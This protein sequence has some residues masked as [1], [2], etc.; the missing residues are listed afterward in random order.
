MC[1]LPNSPRADFRHTYMLWQNTLW[2]KKKGFLPLTASDQ[3]S[4]L[5]TLSLQDPPFPTKCDHDD[6]EHE[7][8]TPDM[9]WPVNPTQLHISDSFCLRHWPLNL[10]AKP[11]SRTCHI[12]HWGD[13]ARKIEAHDNRPSPQPSPLCWV[14]T[15]SS[16]DP[17]CGSPAP[18]QDSSE[19][20]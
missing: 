5:L 11:E 15:G 2:A 3:I 1:D 10:R 20:Y 6:A 7:A 13:L 4:M 8:F 14:T 9:T 19:E 18:S 17:P 12:S 16:R